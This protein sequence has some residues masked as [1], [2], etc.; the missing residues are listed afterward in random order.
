MLE[1]MADLEVL[2]VVATLDFA[3]RHNG[4]GCLL[5]VRRLAKN[6]EAEPVF[7]GINGCASTELAAAGVGGL[8]FNETHGGFHASFGRD[9]P[10]TQYRYEDAG[11][12]PC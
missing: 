10:C 11:L 6:P 3:H 1:K 9:D 8:D 12:R 4:S 5:P 2:E 7:Y